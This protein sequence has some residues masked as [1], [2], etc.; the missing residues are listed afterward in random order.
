MADPPPE[1]AE[2]GGVDRGRLRL[3]HSVTLSESFTVEEA[4]IC[5]RPKLELK[6]NIGLKG[7]VHSKTK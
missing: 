5:E 1:H 7:T 4:D 2:G 3:D 6:V